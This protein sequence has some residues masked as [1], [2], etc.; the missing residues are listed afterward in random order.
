MPAAAG[1]GPPRSRQ[2]ATTPL[3]P[4]PPNRHNRA[5]PRQGNLT[6]RD[7]ATAMRTLLEVLAYAHDMGCCHLDIKVWRG[8]HGHSTRSHGA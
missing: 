6:E 7:A 1:D 4:H 2:R 5:A 8:Q 3:K